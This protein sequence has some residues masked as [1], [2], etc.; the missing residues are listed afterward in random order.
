[1]SRID[2]I[3]R[4]FPVPP[5]DLMWRV[6]DSTDPEWFLDSGLQS[7]RD[8]ERA[9]GVA[10]CE[11][12][13]ARRIL[14]YGCGCGRMLRWFADLDGPAIHGIDIDADA[15][16]W[17]REHL[18]FAQLHVGPGVPP[19]DFEDDYFDLVVNHSVFT[20]LD[21]E[22]QDRWMAELQRISADD[23]LL[24]LSAST[25]TPFHEYE[26][27]LRDAGVDPSPARERIARDGILHITEDSW[28]GGPFPDFY[29]STFHAPWYLLEHWQQWFE[30]VAYIPRGNLGFQDTVVMRNRPSDQRVPVIA[31][32]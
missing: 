17:A 11:L 19:T 23:A 13:Q 27:S 9:L 30:L 7:R 1:M 3:G 14:D 31:R 22:Y 15:I 12:A 28:R 32:R 8:L 21:A 20:H 2:E 24:V 29:H 6:T 16:A 5:D 26:E 25:E 4:E 10:G 18:T